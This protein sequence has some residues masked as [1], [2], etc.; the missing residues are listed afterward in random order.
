[1]TLSTSG[2]ILYG[3]CD[4]YFD[5]PES[6]EY[7]VKRV[8][9]FGADWIVARTDDGTLGFASFSSTEQMFTLV[10]EWAKKENDV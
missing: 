1:M 2:T 6:H 5:I 9:A 10:H 4:G 8:V 7:E 3:Y